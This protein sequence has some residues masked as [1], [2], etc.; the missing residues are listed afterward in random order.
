MTHHHQLPRTRER[1]LVSPSLLFYF[2]FGSPLTVPPLSYLIPFWRVISF[3][4]VPSSFL[5][6]VSPQIRE[7]IGYAYY[8]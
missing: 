2:P 7:L 8:A 5:I 4:P 3:R 6:L 1:D